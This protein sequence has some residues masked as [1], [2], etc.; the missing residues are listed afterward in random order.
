[1][2]RPE[3]WAVA[4]A[5]G[6]RAGSVWLASYSTMPWHDPDEYLTRAAALGASP[7]IAALNV[8]GYIRAPLYP[9]LLRLALTGGLST[10]ALLYAQTL[11]SG[12]TVLGA[13]AAARALGGARAGIVAAFAVACSPLS[14]AVAPS[15]WSE[16]LAVPLVT[17]GLAALVMSMERPSTARLIVAGVLFGAAAL[18][19]SATLY[20]FPIIA[21]I[22]AWRL[23]WRVGVAA[24]VFAALTLSYIA[25]CSIAAGRLILIENVAERDWAHESQGANA[26]ATAVR[27][28]LPAAISV[29]FDRPGSYLRE[30]LGRLHMTLSPRPWFWPDARPRSRAV[31]LGLALLV[32]GLL[33]VSAIAAPAGFAAARDRAAAGVLAAWIALHVALIVIMPV[34]ASPRYRA[35]WEPALCILGS[36]ALARAPLL[37]HRK[38]AVERQL[39]SLADEH[40]LADE[41]TSRARQRLDPDRAVRCVHV[42]PDDASLADVD[43]GRSAVVAE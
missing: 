40:A 5:I 34:T 41:R 37:L 36:M 8:D 10:S 35:P 31:A 22:A 33:I 2:K 17:C 42:R 16:Q 7:F 9:V 21:L 20:L 27:D 25:A 39:D 18:T 4:A 12:L 14:V 30:G 26:E 29:A 11:V 38:G 15:F 3:W 28:M 13:F 32:G 43:G 24:A 1:M 23:R 19:R 6:L